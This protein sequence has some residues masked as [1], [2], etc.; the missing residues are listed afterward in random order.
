MIGRQPHIFTV[1]KRNVSLRVVAYFAAFSS[2]DLSPSFPPSRPPHPLSSGPTHLSHTWYLE[3][4]STPNPEAI[5]CLREKGVVK[6]RP[7]KVSRF[8]G[9][10]I[11]AGVFTTFWTCTSTHGIPTTYGYMPSAAG[12]ERAQ[13]RTLWGAQKTAQPF[14]VFDSTHTAFLFRPSA[15]RGI[16]SAP[17][18]TLPG[19]HNG[20]ISG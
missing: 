2:K 8:F 17:D 4:L 6:I 14:K 20:R 3:V 15:S 18:G 1:P 19:C 13:L 10:S 12:V 5:L 11:T 16:S 7:K 9:A